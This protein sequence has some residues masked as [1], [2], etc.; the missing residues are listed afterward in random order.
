MALRGGY[1]MRETQTGSADAC[2]GAERTLVNT[3]RVFLIQYE[4]P[5]KESQRRVRSFLPLKGSEAP[6]FPQILTKASVSQAPLLLALFWLWI[7]FLD[8]L[9]SASLDCTPV[10]KTLKPMKMHGW[11]HNSHRTEVF[12][13]GSSYKTTLNI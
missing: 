6:Q 4:A 13:W 9:K 5:L 8:G 10:L 3:G 2:L 12:S 11:V 7:G 1:L